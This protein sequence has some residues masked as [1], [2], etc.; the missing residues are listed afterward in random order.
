MSLF[1]EWAHA[2]GLFHE[3][4]ASGANVMTCSATISALEKELLV[5]STKKIKALKMLLDFLSHD[6]D[7][8]SGV[9]FA[10]YHDMASPIQKVWMKSCESPFGWIFDAL[11][12]G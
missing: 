6:F 12:L 11:E 8:H 1:E 7:A 10:W 3:A 9:F 2:L 5:Q 4:G